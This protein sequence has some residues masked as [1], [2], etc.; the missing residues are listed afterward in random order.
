MLLDFLCAGIVVL[1][2][3]TGLV[4]GL[5]LQVLRL[6]ASAV[7]AAAALA[8]TGPAMKAFPVLADQ[9]AAREV[10]Y[11]FAIFTTLYL[12]MDVVARL[13]V[14]LLHLVTGPLSFPD[15]LGGL[16]LG[17]L[18]G[19]VLVYFLVAV[20]LSTEASTGGTLAR[21]DTRN[22]IVAGW[23]GAW[24]VGRLR[25]L[26]RIRMLRDLDVDVDMSGFLPGRR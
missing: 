22:S 15:R 14:A 19:V 17:A 18:K 7:A 9:P 1:F 25:D 11:P 23:V 10:L 26:T 5:L 21:L 6:A 3:V 2:A 8:L 24:P 4:S 12:V 13:L 20:G 16:V